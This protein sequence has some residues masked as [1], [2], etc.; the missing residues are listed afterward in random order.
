MTNIFNI[1]TYALFYKQKIH[2]S[3]VYPAGILFRAHSKSVK[4]LYFA[5][6]RS[7]LFFFFMCISL[8][9]SENHF[10]KCAANMY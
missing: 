8:R 9:Y 7:T 5:P 2:N 6:T 10:C 1:H 4:D 3:V